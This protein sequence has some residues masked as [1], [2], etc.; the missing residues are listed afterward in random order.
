LEKTLLAAVGETGPRIAGLALEKP[1]ASPSTVI[2]SAEP[3]ISVRR[4]IRWRIG[5]EI[6]E[7]IG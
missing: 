7:P 5:S 4:S 6:S 3:M 1:K 2:V